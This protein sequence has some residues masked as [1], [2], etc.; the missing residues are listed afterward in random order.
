[1]SSGITLAPLKT[2]IIVDLQGFKDDMSKAAALGVSEAKKISE[3]LKNV[4]KVG[5]NLSEFGGKMTKYVTAPIIG[6]GTAMTGMAV[7]FGTDFAKVST[8]LDEN[9]VDFSNYKKELLTASND[10]K[11][12]IGEF[13]EAVYGSIS[14]GVDQTKAIEF[15]TEA[16][17]LAKGGFTTGAKAVDVMTTAING[18][19]L[20]TEEATK[21]SDY[22]IT[23]QNLGKT[24]VDE[25][26]SSMGAVIPVASNAN[27]AM[28]ELSAGFALM[29][30]N[31]IAT[32]EAGT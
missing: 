25:L 7:S 4:T 22:L 11:V 28:N 13:S 26:A 5:E 23:T 20:S 18:Y 32:S 2:E 10:S 27:F 31:G 6:I 9:V 14:A 30:K 17:K 1:M 21:I 15:T 16:M 12:A 3:E 29:T 8:L 19:K 24:T